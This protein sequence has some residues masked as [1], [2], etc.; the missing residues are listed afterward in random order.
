MLNSNLVMYVLLFLVFVSS[1]YGQGTVV[2]TKYGP[3]E[4][5]VVDLG[6]G[7]S[8]L[9]FLA[10]P[11]ARPPVESLR[12]QVCINHF[13]IRFSKYLSLTRRLKGHRY[14]C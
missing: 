8:V 5:H 6:N 10:V 4:G 14:V 13:Q 7:Q 2:N 1:C 3:V 12:F 9:S 11:Y